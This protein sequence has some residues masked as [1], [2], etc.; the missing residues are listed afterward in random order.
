[1]FDLDFFRR[2]PEAFTKLANEFLIQKKQPGV[3]ETDVETEYSWTT[4][5]TPTHKFIQAL[6]KIG[7]LDK[8]FTINI[9]NTESRFLH[10]SKLV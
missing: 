7:I 4:E 3:G 1:M 10:Q 8:Y 6:N 5:L 2:K 9:E